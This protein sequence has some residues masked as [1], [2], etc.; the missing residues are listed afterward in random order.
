MEEGVA[1]AEAGGDE[2]EAVVTPEGADAIEEGMADGVCAHEQGVTEQNAQ[3]QE[4]LALKNSAHAPR[5]GA[6]RSG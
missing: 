6:A 4:P 3:G 5:D 1:E 2:P